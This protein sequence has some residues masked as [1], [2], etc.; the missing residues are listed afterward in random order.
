MTEAKYIAIYRDLKQKISAGTYPVGSM[1]PS[2][3]VLAAQ[4]ETSR[5]T[6]RKALD[7]LS[8]EGV[9]ARRRGAGTTVASQP[10]ISDES[11]ITPKHLLGTRQRFADRDFKTQV[12]SFTMHQAGDDLAGKLHI[13]PSDVVY[14]IVRLRIVDER[15]IVIEY[16]YMP[17][18][19]V[20]G[21]TEDVLATSIYQYLTD[22]LQFD[23][24]A[25]NIKI[26]GVQATATECELLHLSGNAVVIE[27]QQTG[28][29]TSGTIFEYSI[30]HHV[31]SAFS[32]QTVVKKEY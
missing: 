16:T 22:E 7:I 2:G 17:V 32:F 28:F 21:L 30:S 18:L 3:D 9:V 13:A 26:S 15:P 6:L 20:P 14:R 8:R 23:I 1:L 12:I 25:A 5:I 10:I 24:D 27:N 29:L 31:P 4:Y 11:L 19:L